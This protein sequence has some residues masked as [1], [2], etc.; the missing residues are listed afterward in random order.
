LPGGFLVLEL[1]YDA[2]EHVAALLSSP[3]GE[4]Q[5]ENIIWRRD[6]AGFVRV[7]SARRR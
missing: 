3:D 4:K 5:W 2:Q 1:G 7:V 6:L